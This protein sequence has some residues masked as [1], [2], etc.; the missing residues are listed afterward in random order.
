MQHCNLTTPNTT[1]WHYRF[2]VRDDLLM[3]PSC[4][5]ATV[6]NSSDALK[7]QMVFGNLEVK[8]AELS[9]S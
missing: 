5:V 6:M 7:L 9:Q 4:Y 1:C 2:D 8:V 3:L